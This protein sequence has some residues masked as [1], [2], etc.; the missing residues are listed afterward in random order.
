MEAAIIKAGV[1]NES[2]VL[3]AVVLEVYP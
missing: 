3:E 2:C 1:A